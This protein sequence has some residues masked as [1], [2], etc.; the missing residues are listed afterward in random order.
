MVLLP[1]DGY[2]LLAWYGNWVLGI[3]LL[4]CRL[5]QSSGVPQLITRYEIISIYLS[6]LKELL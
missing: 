2:E 3:G 6:S 4:F 5:L 1:F